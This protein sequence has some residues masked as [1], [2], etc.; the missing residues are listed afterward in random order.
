MRKIGSVDLE[1]GDVVIVK[2]LLGLHLFSLLKLLSRLDAEKG[3]NS[4]VVDNDLGKSFVN[5][6]VNDFGEIFNTFSDCFELSNTVDS[7]ETFL[8]NLSMCDLFNVIEKFLDINSVAM[9]KALNL[10]TNITCLFKPISEQIS[11]K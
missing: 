7:K 3:V 5:F 8:L 2:E 9:I 6:A 1:N 11:V 10:I 4:E